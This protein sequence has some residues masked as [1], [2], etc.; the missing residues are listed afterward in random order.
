M[1]QKKAEDDPPAPPALDQMPT[2]NRRRRLDPS[3]ISKK[4]PEDDLPARPAR[5]NTVVGRVWR[6]RNV[7]ND[8]P[9]SDTEN[10]KVKEEWSK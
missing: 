8:Q 2:S 9:E 3:Q 7:K 10:F 1:S 6:L 4:K 5:S